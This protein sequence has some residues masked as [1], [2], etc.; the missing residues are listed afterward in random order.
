MQ[1][2][3][4]ECDSGLRSDPFGELLRLTIKAVSGGVEHEPRLDVG[5][6]AGQIERERPPFAPN[7]PE[8]SRFFTPLDQLGSASARC[9]GDDLENERDKRTWIMRRRERVADECD[10]LSRVTRRRV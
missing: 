7:V 4:L 5:A 10:C 2:R 3:I 6:F 8:P 9:F 1:P